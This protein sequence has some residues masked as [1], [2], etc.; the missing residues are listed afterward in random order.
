MTPGVGYGFTYIH[1]AKA[2]IWAACMAHCEAGLS[3]AP[4]TMR[5]WQLMWQ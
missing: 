1:K 2:A 3:M 4:C 5:Q